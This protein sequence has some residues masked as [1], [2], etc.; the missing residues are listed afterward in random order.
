MKV[1][2]AIFGLLAFAL[3][4]Q[5]Q[6]DTAISGQNICLYGTALLEGFDDQAFRT[7]CQVVNSNPFAISASPGNSGVTASECETYA[8][9]DG[10]IC[11]QFYS[12][13]NCAYY[14]GLCGL[15]PCQYFCDN[16]ATLCPTATAN[17]C[18]QSISCSSGTAGSTCTEWNINANNIPTATTHVT[19]TGTG[20]T[21]HIT[22][23]EQ[24]FTSGASSV[25]VGYSFVLCV[26]LAFFAF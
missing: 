10:N 20:S 6:C 21:T 4:V 12:K 9:A 5:A 17:H 2:L 13:Y 25:W 22:T 26:V 16:F 24:H 18:F 8:R 11:I 1:F 19:T 14:C 23:T 15:E 3:H 7:E